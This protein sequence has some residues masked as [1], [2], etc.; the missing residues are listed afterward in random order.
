MKP[1]QKL[2]Q[3]RV[4]DILHLNGIELSE[5]EKLD[6]ELD[7]EGNIKVLGIERVDDEGNTGVRR[8]EDAK[9]AAAIEAALAEDATLGKDL[10]RLRARRVVK[11]AVL[12][13]IVENSEK[14]EEEREWSI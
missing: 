6:L 9:K 8:I 11:D 4:A 7:A 14:P 12:A 1:D 5:D 13:S 3:D 2:L 10:L